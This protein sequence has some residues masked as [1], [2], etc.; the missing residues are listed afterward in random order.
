MD[1]GRD[2]QA[3]RRRCHGAVVA[4]AVL[5]G[6][7]HAA[8]AKESDT[9]L[10]NKT[11]GKDTSG[12]EICVVEQFA[13]AMPQKAVVLRIRFAPVEN[14][15]QMRMM[16]TAPLGIRLPPGLTL[17]VDGGQ[18]TGLPFERCSGEGCDAVAVL[19]KSA[20]EMFTHGKTLSVRYV[21]SEQAGVD[22]PIKLDGMAAAL[23]S[24]SR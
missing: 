12:Q 2:R 3:N 1:S 4:I 21:V 19:D 15:E 8:P 16:V 24:L 14:R 17:N 7:T 5:L 6:L 18:A 10:W 11:C 9:P 23:H 20:L 13:V 22:I